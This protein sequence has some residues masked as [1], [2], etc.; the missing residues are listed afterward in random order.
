MMIDRL[1]APITLE[2]LRTR[3]ADILRLARQ[4]GA[5]NVRVFGSVARGEAVT[6]SDVD[7]LVD[8]QSGTSLWDV[9]GL[10]QDLSA[11]LGC[12]VSVVT[13]STLQGRFRHNVL[14]DAVPL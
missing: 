12:E 6:G 5:S 1:N 11:L 7:F 4:H 14:R 10:W 2:H 8:F 13:E 9:I 3:R